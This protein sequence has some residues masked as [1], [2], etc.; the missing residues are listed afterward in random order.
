MPLSVPLGRSRGQSGRPCQSDLSDPLRMVL[1]VLCLMVPLDQE[2][3][4][5]HQ[6]SPWVLS[7]QLC[8]HCPWGLSDLEQKTPP[9]EGRSARLRTVP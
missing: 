4:N 8:R 2:Q 1:S 3:T 5:P 6:S 9:L 7:A